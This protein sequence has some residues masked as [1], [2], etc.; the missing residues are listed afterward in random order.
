VSSQTGIAG[1]TG[2]TDPLD[3]VENRATGDL[4]V[5]EFGADRIT[6]LRPLG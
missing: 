3:L 1:L 5:T 6:L 4:Y 2:L